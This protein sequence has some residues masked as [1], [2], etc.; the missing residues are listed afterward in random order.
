MTQE[1]ALE[2]FNNWHHANFGQKYPENLNYIGSFK[3]NVMIMDG[4]HDIHL[5][6]YTK[7]NGKLGRG[8]CNPITW[9]FRVQD[10]SGMSN[11]DLVTA[12]CGWALI[13]RGTF[14]KIVVP[15]FQD[16]DSSLLEIS[17]RIKKEL[18]EDFTLK[19]KYVIN[20]NVIYAEFEG[21]VNG[22]RAKQAIGNDG[23]SLYLEESDTRFAL[24]ALWTL[25]GELQQRPS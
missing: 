20:D 22:I 21:T 7:N 23:S 24:P 14:T 16:K 6:S 9:T 3:R 18:S 8:F 12:Y 10:D 2:T 17:K 25:L 5:V 4:F 13:F 11:D 15:D 1:E 19:S